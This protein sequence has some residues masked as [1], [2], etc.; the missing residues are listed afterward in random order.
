MFHAS[1]TSFDAQASVGP[2]MWIV[3]LLL[4]T[5]A[6]IVPVVAATAA[7]ALVSA[8]VIAAVTTIVVARCEI[9]L[10]IACGLIGVPSSVAA[11]RHSDEHD[12]RVLRDRRTWRRRREQRDLDH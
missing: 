8:T 9:A 6:V 4:L 7:P 12:R 1:A 5:H 11:S 2:T 3:P 10:K